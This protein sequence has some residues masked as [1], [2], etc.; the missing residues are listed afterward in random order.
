MSYI[1]RD[2]LTP[3]TAKVASK[4]FLSHIDEGD[5]PDVAEV[6]TNKDLNTLGV[7]KAAAERLAY[8]AKFFHK[9]F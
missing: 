2:Y 5:S 1:Y 6:R 8:R 9:H 4:L 3:A 7:P